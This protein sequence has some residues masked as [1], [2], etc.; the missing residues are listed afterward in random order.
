V[1]NAKDK[2]STRRSR[3][4]GSVAML[5]LA[6]ASTLSLAG[7]VD[8]TQ[9]GPKFKGWG[10]SLAWWA[11]ITGAWN[12]SERFESL[13]DAVYNVEDGLGLTIV[14]LNIGAGQNP[15]LP[16]GYML[17]GR[18]MP[19]YQP[20]PGQPFNFFADRAQQR[21]LLA[22][23]ERGVRYV[24]ANGNSP[25]WW[26][27]VTQD[28]SGNP[29]GSNLAPSDY[30]DFGAYLAEVALWYRDTL[31]VEFSSITPLNEPS[32]GWWDGNGNQEGCTI[33]HAAQPA[34]LQ[35]LRTE[36]DARGLQDLS[37]SGPEEWSPELGVQGLTQYPMSVLDDLSHISTH[38][39]NTNQRLQLNDLAV[40]LGKPLWMT[41]YGLGGSDLYDSALGLA[42]RIIGDF[43][44]MPHL[45][46]WIIWQ[47]MSTSHFG[48]TWSCML[49]NFETGAPGFTLRPQFYTYA[50]FTRFIRP[51]SYFIES[52]D[53]NTLAAY[54]PAQ[55]RL[56]L[57]ALNES[58]TPQPVSF[59]LGRFTELPD[60][61][62][63]HRTR[64]GEWII[65]F[66]DLPLAG[67][68]FGV[69]LAPSSLATFVFEGVETPVLTQADWNG[70][71]NRDE[72]DLIEFLDDLDHGADHADIDANGSIDFFDALAFLS[73]FDQAGPLETVYERTFSEPMG[74]PTDIDLGNG[75]SG[76]QYV[77]S[78]AMFVQAFANNAENG[79]VAFPLP[80]VTLEA[81]VTYTVELEAGDFNQNWTTGG[82]Y[83][84]GLSAAVPTIQSTG[85]LGSATFRVATN[86]GPFAQA[87]E[88][89]RFVITPSATVTDPYFL[90]RTDAVASGNQRVA[91]DSVRISR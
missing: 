34:V 76:G 15:D 49:S 17:P 35:A 5:A 39:Y 83:V 16:E 4:S 11:N 43:D 31:G 45:E 21:V 30:D 46:A 12:D 14:R 3:R 78:G 69:T 26:M 23:L 29:N 51:G 75:A 54:N 18:S 90:I 80:G 20:G 8:P 57:V 47:V 71:G 52:G 88:S 64:L 81:G 86:N 32:A 68:T 25:P 19:A 48:H 59:D 70:D 61:A 1:I 44:E 67:D 38:T 72:Q 87:F 77:D 73:E 60:S 37:I 27:T 2:L 6:A 84:V 79:G 63:Y 9:H 58:A 82:T 89:R 10:T 28:A 85:D 91:I 7:E 24:E 65:Q 53:A 56:T 42:R 22:G 13:M 41:E 66:P 62:E 74:L 50:H 36:L 33:P 40:T 55:K